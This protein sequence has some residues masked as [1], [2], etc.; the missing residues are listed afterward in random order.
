MRRRHSVPSLVGAI[1]AV[2]GCRDL[3]GPAAELA[4]NRAKWR[5][6]RPEAYTYEYARVCG[7]CSPDWVQPVRITVEGDAVTSVVVIATGAPVAP[8]AFRL[9]M[10]SLFTR[11]ESAIGQGVHRIAI[12]YDRRLGYPTSAYVDHDQQT[13]DDEWGFDARLVAP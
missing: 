13:V 7:E 12:Q 4:V 5:A 3:F 11:L 8:P 9:T 6:A 2:T 10:D 1:L